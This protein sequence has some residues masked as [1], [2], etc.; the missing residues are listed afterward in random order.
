MRTI[1]SALAFIFECCS[2]DFGFAF[3][4]RSRAKIK[5]SRNVSLKEVLESDDPRI[6]FLIG[7]GLRRHEARMIL[8]REIYR[9]SN[10]ELIAYVRNGKGGKAR[11]VV[12][13]PEYADEIERMAAAVGSDELIIGKFPSS[14]PAHFC[15][16]VYAH[17]YYRLVARD[18]STLDKKETYR[19]R[20]D[21]K[22]KVFDRQAMLEVSRQLGHNRVSV[23]AGHY[24]YDFKP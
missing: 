1:G 5:R 10:G 4:T 6:H 24:L 21:M 7:S 20:G 19:M 13:L 11:E 23:I 15:R 3:E 2:T 8:G 17:E 14:I 18:L 12:I 22:G 9:N 16:A